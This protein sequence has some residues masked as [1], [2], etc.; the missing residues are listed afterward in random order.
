MNDDPS[1]GPA[2]SDRLLGYLEADPDN[3]ALIGDIVEAALAEGRPDLARRMISRLDA[4][5][6]LDPRSAHLAGLEAMHR[7]D[8]AEAARRFGDLRGAGLDDPALRFNHAWSLAMLGRHADALA[9]IDDAAARASAPAAMLEIQLRHQL[10]PLEDAAVRARALAAVHPH[11]QGLMAAISVLGIDL[12]D[13]GLAEEAA[14]KAGDHPDAL[15]TRGTLALDAGEGDAALALFAR[16]LHRRDHTPRAWIGSGL[17][18]LS[19]GDAASATR[20]LDRGAEMFGTHPGSWLAAGWAHVLARRFDAARERFERAREADPAFSEAHGALAVV[21]LAEGRVEDAER[22]A[23]VALRLDRECF[24]AAL[25]SV[26]LADAAGDGERAR[27]LF[28]LAVHR[29]LDDRGT[30]IAQHLA[31]LRYQGPAATRS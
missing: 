6:D 13:E 17:A 20:D 26:L 11:D 10:G 21:D 8:F 24:S 16:A 18:R 27:R 2:R 28:D 31:G 1:A 7:R 19:M 14:G 5:G 12:G 15:A 30:T 9:E 4:A 29:P 22:R 23:Q 25:A 3:R